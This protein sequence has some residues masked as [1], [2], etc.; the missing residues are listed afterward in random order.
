V[1]TIPDSKSVEYSS[2]YLA[3]DSAVTISA[4]ALRRRRR[5]VPFLESVV[6]VAVPAGII[7]I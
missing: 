1:A 5:V 6:A 4:D 2:K 7:V 3:L